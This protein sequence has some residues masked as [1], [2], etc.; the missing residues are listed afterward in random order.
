MDSF[1]CIQYH[2]VILINSEGKKA[3]VQ[4]FALCRFQC[5]LKYVANS[6]TSVVIEGKMAIYNVDM[7]EKNTCRQSFVIVFM[8]SACRRGEQFGKRKK[9]ARTFNSKYIVSK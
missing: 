3:K 2:R 5:L 7:V 9:W 8:L 1:P 6:G 4:Q